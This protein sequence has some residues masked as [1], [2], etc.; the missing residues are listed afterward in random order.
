[1][2]QSQVAEQRD[3]SNHIAKFEAVY[4]SYL[5]CVCKS[6][7]VVLVPAVC[8]NWCAAHWLH[9]CKQSM[10]HGCKSNSVSIAL[11]V[12]CMLYRFKFAAAS[13][14]LGIVTGTV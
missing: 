12:L 14:L 11:T 13:A 5:R 2:L 10:Q 6:F 1:M 4:H 8:T 3:S 9:P 7:D